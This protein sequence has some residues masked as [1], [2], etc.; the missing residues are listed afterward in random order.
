MDRGAAFI[1]KSITIQAENT[2]KGNAAE[3]KAYDLPESAFAGAL[4]NM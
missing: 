4:Q 1:S 3:V 2:Q